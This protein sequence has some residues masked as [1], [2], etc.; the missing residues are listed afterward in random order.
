MR[1]TTTTDM[2]A[3]RSLMFNT[4][5]EAADFLGITSEELLQ[6]ERGRRWTLFSDH[7]EQLQ[8]LYATFEYFREEIEAGGPGR[9]LIVYTGDGVY[10]DMEKEWPRVLPTAAVHFRAAI[11]AAFALGDDAPTLVT[12]N[13]TSYEEFRNGRPDTPALRQNWAAHYVTNYKLQPAR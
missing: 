10:S 3:L 13:P 2:K 12:M 8:G 5:H 4:T 6:A 7:V 9:Y 1:I 11:L